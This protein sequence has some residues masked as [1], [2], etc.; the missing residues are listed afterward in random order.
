MAAGGD[1][2]LETVLSVDVPEL[3][4]DVA[5]LDGI[6]LGETLLEEELLES[7]ELDNELEATTLLEVLLEDAVVE[8]DVEATVGETCPLEED[9][10]TEV[11]EDELTGED[12][13]DPAPDGVE[14]DE[15]GAKEE[16]GETVPI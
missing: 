7:A 9:P 1:E 4:I 12:E 6:E 10:T 11:V 5:V 16:E 3:E 13:E 14:V 2:R 15:E 8:L